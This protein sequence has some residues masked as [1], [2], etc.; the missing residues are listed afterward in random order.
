MRALTGLEGCLEREAVLEIDAK[1]K[2]RVSEKNQL[3]I[4]DLR[5]VS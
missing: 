1:L 4:G 5:A 2:E 3:R